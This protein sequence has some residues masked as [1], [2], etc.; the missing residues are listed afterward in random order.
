MDLHQAFVGQKADK[1]LTL[2]EYAFV[3]LRL[4]PR[5]ETFGHPHNVR[6]RFGLVTHRADNYLLVLVLPHE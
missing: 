5:A 4:D 6:N 3:A 2:P 1:R